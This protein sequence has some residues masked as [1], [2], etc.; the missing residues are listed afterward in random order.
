MV[1]EVFTRLEYQARAECAVMVL[2]VVFLCCPLFE[3]PSF[4]LT[5][6]RAGTVSPA[7][8]VYIR[9]ALVRA[10]DAR[11]TEALPRISA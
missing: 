11:A 3:N 1:M 8:N 5:E 10:G 6:G 4:S 2:L 9:K 7:G